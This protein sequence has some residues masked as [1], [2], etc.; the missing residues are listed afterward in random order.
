MFAVPFGPSGDP[1]VSK[2]RADCFP[3]FLRVLLMVHLLNVLAAQSTIDNPYL[4][5]SLSLSLPEL[6][7]RTELKGVCLS[8]FGL[9]LTVFIS[10]FSAR[11]M[12]FWSI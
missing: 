6:G 7:I 12:W 1:E 9:N 8:I 2:G 10:L 5:L 4:S 11:T 3:R